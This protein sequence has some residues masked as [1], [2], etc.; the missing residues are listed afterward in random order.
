MTERGLK[1]VLGPLELAVLQIL[2]KQSPLTVRE[3]RERLPRR[4]NIAYTTVMTIIHRLYEKRFLKR[5]RSGVAHLYRPALTREELE[6]QLVERVIS[7]LWDDF[8][9]LMQRQAQG[10]RHA[11]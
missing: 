6:A 5:R 1:R 11:V 4:G 9:E 2:W 8:P 10:L 3:V 7:G